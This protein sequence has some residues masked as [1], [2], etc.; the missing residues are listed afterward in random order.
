[1]NFENLHLQ[2]SEE[3]KEINLNQFDELLEVFDY[4]ESGSLNTFKKFNLEKNNLLKEI[5]EKFILYKKKYNE[6]IIAKSNFQELSNRYEILKR[7]LIQ[8]FPN[9]NEIN[10]T[11]N[12]LQKNLNKV[13]YNTKQIDMT[14]EF[15]LSSIHKKPK[16][17]N[18]SSK[19]K[20]EQKQ[21]DIEAQSEIIKTISEDIRVLLE[22][23]KPQI[24]E[25]KEK[26]RDLKLPRIELITNPLNEKISEINLLGN[27]LINLE[28]KIWNIKKEI[29]S[30][31]IL[32]K[33][34]KLEIKK[35]FRKLIEKQEQKNAKD[36]QLRI[37]T[38]FSNKEEKFK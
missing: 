21:K 6:Y 14:S 11:L 10:E 17:I 4:F 7:D 20:Q 8:N 38:I 12:L 24:E 18:F 33:N 9:I 29:E 19:N 31:I 16:K 36:I 25:I 37:N 35:Y 34:K 27:N 28:N 5:N 32:L 30:K 13:L 1:M 26:T 22:M 2:F 15:I 23:S 3:I